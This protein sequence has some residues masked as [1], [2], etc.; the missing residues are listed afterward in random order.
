MEAIQ[1]TF[2]Y[3]IT[4]EQH[5]NYW[6]RLH[7]LKYYTV[8]R[9]AVNVIYNSIYFKLTLHMVP[10]IDGTMG[11]KIK[12][13]KHPGQG[14]TCSVLFSIEQTETQHTPFKKMQ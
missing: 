6:E 5:L 9:D 8:S 7:E 11:D 14:N 4:D 13:R 1:R 12:T 2:T 3:K 10:N